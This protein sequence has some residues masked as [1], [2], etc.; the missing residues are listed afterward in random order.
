MAVSPA[1][2]QLAMRSGSFNPK[3]SVAEALLLRW[4]T[5]EV[6]ARQSLG[7]VSDASLAFVSAGQVRV[8]AAHGKAIQVWNVG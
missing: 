7:V 8:A 3:D 4:P 5:G 2:T 1:G 6:V